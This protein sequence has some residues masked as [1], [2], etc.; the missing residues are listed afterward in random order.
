MF[1][2][3]IL[4]SRQS[5]EHAVT[6]HY[7]VLGKLISNQ[8]IL[9]RPRLG[10]SCSSITVA[11]D[12]IHTC[13]HISFREIYNHLLQ[14]V[15]QQDTAKRKDKDLFKTLTQY[16]STILRGRSP[17]CSRAITFL[18]YILHTF[19][20]FFCDKSQLPILQFWTESKLVQAA[21]KRFWFEIYNHSGNFSKNGHPRTNLM[22]KTRRDLV[23][24]N[25]SICEHTHSKLAK[26]W[27]N[28]LNTL[29][30]D[31]KTESPEK[32]NLPLVSQA[33]IGTKY[34]EMID[35]STG[36]V[37]DT[38]QLND[39][40]SKGWFFLSSH[41]GTSP[42]YKLPLSADSKSYPETFN[43]HYYDPD[44]DNWDVRHSNRP[45]EVGINPDNLLP[46]ERTQFK[47]LIKDILN[48]D[49]DYNG[50]KEYYHQFDTNDIILTDDIEEGRMPKP[51]PEQMH[52]YCGYV[53]R[54]TILETPKSSSIF[55]F[56]SK[57]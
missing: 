12:N 17:N 43:Q 11:N 55:S 9:Q 46:E 6:K 7:H 14:T 28:Q 20:K 33:L 52:V 27:M 53:L 30:K 49:R 56:F 36:A 13:H 47:V 15:L 51:N 35:T 25:G 8:T 2:S 57:E 41:P 31:N 45:C 21:F 48:K 3:A 24:V 22:I 29:P 18:V 39:M 38:E 10:K 23:Y 54:S 26:K 44:N 37:L 1:H 19:D 4:S 42:R 32:Y 34:T 40:Y 50:G 16:F 5:S